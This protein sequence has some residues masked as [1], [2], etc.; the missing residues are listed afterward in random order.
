M[1]K[2][3]RRPKVITAALS[4]TEIKKKKSESNDHATVNAIAYSAATEILK[5]MN[6]V[7]GKT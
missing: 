5:E 7:L 6:H 3:V 4:K 1:E 2:N